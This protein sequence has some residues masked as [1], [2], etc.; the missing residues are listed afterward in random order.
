MAAV[1]E[2]ERPAKVSADALEGEPLGGRD[3]GEQG[4]SDAL[5]TGEER[6]QAAGRGVNWQ[7]GGPGGGVTHAGFGS[8]H[9]GRA[10]LCLNQACFCICC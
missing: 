8:G 10:S 1:D 9:S 7:C 2:G 3:M 4:G 5:A 6:Q